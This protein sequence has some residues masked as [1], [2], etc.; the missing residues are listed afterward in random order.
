LQ[1]SEDRPTFESLRYRLED[2]FT[3]EAANYTEA[4]KV[5]EAAQEE[6]EEEEKG[7]DDE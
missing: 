4:Q 3:S 6:E 1:N 2:F 5:L 7:E